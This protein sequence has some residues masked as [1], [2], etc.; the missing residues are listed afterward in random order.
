VETDIAETPRKSETNTDLEQEPKRSAR[1]TYMSAVLH[2]CSKHKQISEKTKT[3]PQ[4]N[5][6]TES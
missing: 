4:E 5:E 3:K 1:K 6:C 2:M